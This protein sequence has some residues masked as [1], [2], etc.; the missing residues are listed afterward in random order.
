MGMINGENLYMKL[1]VGQHL[2]VGVIFMV[3]MYTEH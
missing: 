1:K 3:E 2:T